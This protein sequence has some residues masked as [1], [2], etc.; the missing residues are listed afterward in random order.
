MTPAEARSTLV[1]LKAARGM[2]AKPPQP[3]ASPEELLDILL[4]DDIDRFE[5]AAR[6]LE[7]KTGIDALTWSATVELLWSE[8]YGTVALV[9]RELAHRSEA[10][11]TRL[12]EKRDAGREFT[13]RDKELLARATEGVAFNTKAEAALGVLSRDHLAA[14][15]EFAREAL[16]QFPD[17]QRTLRV[18]AFYYLST[19]TWGRYDQVMAALGDSEASDAPLLFLRALEA[20]RRRGQRAEARQYLTHALAVNPRLVRAQAKLVLL[21]DDSASSYAE[22]QK[23]EA[24]SPEHPVVRITGPSIKREY[25]LSESFDRAR[26]KTLP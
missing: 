20:E 26:S 2:K 4:R 16:R 25:E 21:Q 6:F 5:D 11:A 22:L 9:A 23:L 14:G 8:A 19:G 10:E 18:A 17:D 12:G 1:E 15:S 13:E 24:L 3:V 7:G